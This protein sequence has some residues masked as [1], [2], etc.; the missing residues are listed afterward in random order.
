MSDILYT[1]NKEEEQKPLYAAEDF[2]PPVN[3]NK[4]NYTVVKSIAATATGIP[5]EDGDVDF[6]D[7]V[8]NN[9]RATVPEQNA[10]SK[11]S[12]EQAVA[13]GQGNVVQLLLNDVAE[14]NRL[15]NETTARNTEYTRQKLKELTNQAVENTVVRNPAALFNNTPQEINDSTD[16]IT[17]RLSSLATLEKAIKDGQKWSNIIPGLLH[18][19]TPL[20]IWEGRAMG[21]IAVKYGVPEYAITAMSGRSED[22][23]WLASAFKAVPEDKKEEWLAN[24]YK[25]LKEAWTISDWQAA[26]MVVDVASGDPEWT[27]FFDWLDRLGV[28]AGLATASLAVFKSG[29]LF[30]N[31]NALKNAS[32]TI[33]AGGGKDALVAAEAAKITSNAARMQQLKAAGVLAGEA[34][35]VSAALD[36]A[37]LVSLNAAKILP[38]AVTTAAHDLQ[39]VIRQPVEKLIND[40][41][42]VVSAKGIKSADAAAELAE[43]EKTFSK[44]SNPNIHSIDNFNISEDGLTISGKVFYKPTDMSSFLTK[45]AA[46]EYIK[47]NDPSG[48]LKM[49]IV[50]DTTNTGFLV[51]ADR[52]QS[53][54]LQKTAVESQILGQFSEAAKTTKGKKK[55]AKVKPPKVTLAAPKSLETSKPRYKTSSIVFEDEVDK[56][57]YQVG[58]KT[59]LS[60]SDAEVKEWLQK[61]TGWSDDQIK[62]HAKSV[63]AYLKANEDVVDMDGN[64]M[65]ARQRKVP[66]AS[67]SIG[68]QQSYNE[69]FANLI[70]EPNN[71]TINNVTMTPSVRRADVAEFVGRLGKTLG[72]DDRKIL[73]MQFSDM[74]KSTSKDVKEVLKVI[75]EKHAGAGALHIDYG[76][77]QSI[78]V[79]MREVSPS[80]KLGQVS[81]KGYLEAFA[82]EYGHAFESHFSSKYFSVINDSFNKWLSSK[83]IKFTGQGINKSVLD[84]FPPEALLEFR[85]LTSAEELA[86]NWLDKW[87]AGD[88]AKYRQYEE[89]IH[90]WASSYSEFFADNF[91]KWAFSDEIPT[92]LLGQYFKSIVNGFKTIAAHVQNMLANMGIVADVGKVDENIAK[93]L[94]NHIKFGYENVKR[95]TSNIS[96]IAKE[97]KTIKPSLSS[98]V[99]QLEHINNEL[100]A[101]DD[102]KKG[103]KTGWLVQQPINKTL[104]YSAIGKYADEDI[105][106]ASRFAMG[107]WALS[108]SSELYADRVTGMHQQSRYQKL[109][110]EFVRPSLESLNKKEMVALN[111]AL[112]LGDK[113]GKVFNEIELAGQ[114][115]SIRAREAYFKT[116]ALRDVMWQIRN[117]AAVKHMVRN[118]YVQIN[119]GIKFE[120][121]SNSLFVREITPKVGDN[122]YYADGN[123]VSRIGKKTLEEA[124]SKGLTFFRAPE[125]VKIEGKYHKIIAFKTGSFAS[126][127]IDTVIPYRP[128]EFRRIYSDEY[129]VKF[130]SNY[131]VDGTIE[132]FTTTHRTAANA[133]E[134]NKY[135]KALREAQQLHK[136]G[137]LTIKE[138]SRLMQPYNWKPEDLIKAFDEAQFGDD[139]EIKVVF[140]RTDDDYLNE[141]VKLSNSF[142]S[143]R[144]D[145]LLSVH[146]EDAVNTLSPMDSIAAE[147][148]NTA[149][150]A[151][152]MEWRES[153]VHKWFNTFKEE[154][155]VNVRNMSASEAFSYMYNNKGIYVGVGGEHRLKVAEKIQDYIIDQ[156]NIP[157]LEEK[158]WLGIMRRL[159]ETIEGGGESKPLLKLGVALRATKDY[160]TWARTIAFHSFFAFNPVQFFMQGMNA[161]NAV[162]ISP[163]H[164]LASVKSSALYSLAL[165]SD[166]EDVWKSVAKVN[167]LTNLGLGMSEEDFVQVVRTIR[168]SGLLDG[169]N[170]TSLYGANVGKYG[171][172]NK[173]SRRTATLAATPFNSG[174]G[175]SR[176]VSFD[177]ARREWI[178]NNAGKAWW[179]DDALVKILERQD[180]L[181]QNMTRANRTSWQ[182]GW[183]SIPAQFVQY[184]A[185]LLLNVA[186]SLGGNAR[187]FT[188][189]EATQLILT[190]ALV[191]GTA[192]MFIWPGRDIIMGLV[193]EDLSEEQRLYIQQGVISGL[194]AT[195][196]DGEARLALGSRFNTFRY[197]EDLI[198]GML[199]PEKTF[200]E[201]ASGPSGFAALRIFG[202]LGE[203][204]SIVTKAPMSMATLQTALTEI[205]KSSFSAI[206]NVQKARIAMANYNKVISSSGG[207]MYR[208][209]DT[210]AWLMAF[211]IPPAAQ[212]DLS[213]MYKSS[214]AHKDDIQSSAKLIGK[215]ALM[216]LIALRNNDRE[217]FNTHSSIVHAIINSYDGADYRALMKAAY[218]TEEGT[219]YQRLLTDQA[220]KQWKIEDLI[221]SKGVNE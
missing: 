106:S 69:R 39:K 129:F 14:R 3:T 51:S 172:F 215:H 213:I 139:L 173:I 17:K 193:P 137:K 211:G 107:D 190:H 104:G 23:Q 50:P 148:G 108:T 92:T 122:V 182:R 188:Q 20:A 65:V 7:V 5:S 126:Q 60:K 177:I 102:A 82:H 90:K 201:V 127:K 212:E 22:R 157:T 67:E 44:A 113:E 143:K 120:D 29:K 99:K 77:K 145:K 42:E 16:R 59:K 221:V 119:T 178:T 8:D 128:G 54:R 171:L 117:D 28:V 55:P 101:I 4:G 19:L 192:G 13:K 53:L 91:A 87:A 191:M 219:Q 199:D 175:F 194:I 115:L 89:Q 208:V 73:V 200:M 197:Y 170:T 15:L 9:W 153:H 114:G 63:R 203:G 150:V 155:P 66:K 135:V 45:E 62:E 111:D 217:S 207:S 76:N 196:T 35:G 163:V 183:K 24:L 131:D 133:S 209:T 161:F 10:I 43:I 36:L 142:S 184:Q 206:N 26:L 81:R 202:G 164:G 32:R 83:G 141:V 138:A 166:Q 218:K 118:G 2:V 1:E 112:V 98:L 134:A 168:R 30:S 121:G 18:E 125:P 33:A 198:S 12:I 210:E 187:A 159:S 58:S 174:E 204:I 154:L 6:D 64:I 132:S 52:E 56:A 123:F 96:G 151:S 47:I 167:K 80:P 100:A 37:K 195:L 158:E 124:E 136:A 146:G 130:T 31:A 97:T 68:V 88:V 75:Q 40:L 79:M 160:P 205:G 48:K 186:H 179:T 38:E 95:V 140:N 214:K 78:I 156:M 25:D 103:V 109:L 189:K 152:A 86:V 74:L 21:D 41:Q 185:K 110:T 162:A 57:A 70:S 147:I 169:M 216:G 144:G 116:R 85:A 105:N 49:A 84:V 165:F 71:I 220:Q 93:M 46:E 94:N 72:M 11:M 181:T 27:P 149:Y 180:D 176:L 61:V 34:T